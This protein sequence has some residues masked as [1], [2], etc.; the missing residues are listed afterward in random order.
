MTRTRLIAAMAMLAVALLSAGCGSHRFALIYQSAGAPL[1]SKAAASL[2]AST[3]I[4]A[5][6]GITAKDAPALR[7]RVLADLRAKG[8]DGAR[9]ADVLTAGF[10]QRTAAVPVLV[11]L[12]AVDGTQAIV[13]VEA[14]GEAGSTLTHRRL[15]VFDRATGALVRAVS[16]R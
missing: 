8:A 10:P 15:W 14:F 11:R 12:C 2:A 6:A 3:D 5:L 1:T 13:V 9:V 16:F 7:S 4:S